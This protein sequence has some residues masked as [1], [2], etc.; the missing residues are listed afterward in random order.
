MIFNTS[1]PFDFHTRHRLLRK[2]ANNSTTRSNVFSVW[3]S[4]GLFESGPHTNGDVQMA[5]P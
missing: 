2:V 4:V 5:G 3:V 1:T